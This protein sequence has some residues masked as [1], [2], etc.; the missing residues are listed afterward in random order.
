MFQPFFVDLNLPVSLTRN[1]EVSVPVVVYNYLDKPQTVTL[2]LAEAP[3]FLLQGDAEQRLNLAPRE[4]RSTSYRLKAAKA[5][6]HE[7]RVS[8]FASGIS[9]ALKR[10]IE[11]VP[12]GRRVEH[13][14]NG[15]LQQPGGATL[16]VPDNAIDGS[17]QAFLKIYPSSL[18]Q[19][20]EG[21]DG[22]FQMPHGC[23]EQ[24]SSTTYPNIL[25]LDYLKRTGRSIRRLR[26]RR[27][28]TSTWVI[29][30]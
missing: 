12:D 4:V 30:G 9:D 19:L 23:F 20:V 18:S 29:N 11:V 21:L 8:A 5:G 24:T 26:R 27:G 17:V 13:V 15:T 7:L 28:S 25:A 16:L 6:A 2:K 22:I 14:F 10:S 1:D 3:W